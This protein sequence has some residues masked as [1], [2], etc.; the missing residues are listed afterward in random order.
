MSPKQGYQLPRTKLSMFFKNFFERLF[1]TFDLKAENTIFW[2]SLTFPFLKKIEKCLEREKIYYPVIKILLCQ[3]FVWV[4]SENL[5]LKVLR[6]LEGKT[7]GLDG[8]SIPFCNISADV[9]GSINF[10]LATFTML[11]SSKWWLYLIQFKL[12]KSSSRQPR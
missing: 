4:R 11:N 8:D 1:I 10:Q 2:N 5:N 3:A 12:V 6:M 9:N 7:I